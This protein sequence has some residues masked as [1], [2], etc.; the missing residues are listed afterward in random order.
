MNNSFLSHALKW[1]G[2][3]GGISIFVSLLLYFVH[4]EL[5]L[6]I[7]FS[8][9][10]F[11]VIIVL[12]VYSGKLYRK[13]VGGYIDFK[14]IFLTLYV[15]SL[16]FIV[17]STG[18]NLALF[19]IDSNAYENYVTAQMNNQE[20]RLEF[21]GVEDG[22]AFDDAMEATKDELERN[23]GTASTLQGM[24]ISAGVFLV[25]TLIIGAVLKK[26]KPIFED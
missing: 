13:S 24:L 26:E 22:D 20:S 5:L 4:L 10:F 23:M 17:L 7:S 11:V 1:G 8:F 3:I 12:L 21:F 9:L 2:I 16:V 25:V 14:T 19:A 18:Y 15:T 6:S